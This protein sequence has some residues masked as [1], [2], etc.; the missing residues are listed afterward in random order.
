MSAVRKVEGVATGADDRPKE[1]VSTGVFLFENAQ[2]KNG[3]RCKNG[4]V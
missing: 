1:T 2:I 3:G 4:M